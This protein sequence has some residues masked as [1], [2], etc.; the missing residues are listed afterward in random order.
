MKRLLFAG[1]MTL[2]ACSGPMDKPG[3][4]Q[5]EKDKDTYECMRE[6]YAAGAGQGAAGQQLYDACMTARGYKRK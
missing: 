2:S 3:V 4:A 5:P 1:L 6:S